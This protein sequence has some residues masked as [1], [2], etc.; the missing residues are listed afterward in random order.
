MS[1]KNPCH[2]SESDLISIVLF[3]FFRICIYL[4]INKAD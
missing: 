2:D 1:V 4:Y 3:S